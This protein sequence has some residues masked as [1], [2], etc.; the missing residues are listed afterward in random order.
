MFYLEFLFRIK[1]TNYETVLA[2]STH[3]KPPN[4][5]GKFLVF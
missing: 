4:A 3:E 5:T 2:G 1:L